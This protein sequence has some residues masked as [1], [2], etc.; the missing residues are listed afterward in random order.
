MGG[1]VSFQVNGQTVTIPEEQMR[2][3]AA[4]GIAEQQKNAQNRGNPD[5]L[6]ANYFGQGSSGIP[7]NGFDSGGNVG[8]PAAAD[9]HLEPLD[10][11]R[12]SVSH[13]QDA[14]PAT[15]VMPAADTA[16][17]AATQ[18][19]AAS[20][21]TIGGPAN[22]DGKPFDG[23]KG[24]IG[25][26]SAGPDEPTVTVANNSSTRR[27]YKI[28]G[29]VGTDPQGLNNNMFYLDPGQTATVNAGVGFNG[30]ITD[31]GSTTNATNAGTRQE[32][33]FTQP[34]VTWYDADLEFGGATKSTL[35]PTDTSLRAN[36]DREALVGDHY[37]YLYAKDDTKNR[38]INTQKMT[39]T[40]S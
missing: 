24:I 23:S 9:A 5:M 13:D 36:G 18:A 20:G 8:A 32:I 12:K 31:Q 14:A 40:S 1:T 2:Q 38:D 15:N 27:Y 11:D 19:P 35:G 30:A 28:E 34:G 6:Q 7:V 29:S 3:D 33:N 22:S 17:P 4:R 39:I 16:A 37:A 21:G 10:L 25:A 26:A